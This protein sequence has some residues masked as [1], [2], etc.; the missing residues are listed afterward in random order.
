MDYFLIIAQKCL[1]LSVN[2]VGATLFDLSYF[3]FTLGWNCAQK[4][5]V[6]AVSDLNASKY[7]FKCFYK[8]LLSELSRAK[9]IRSP[10]ICDENQRSRVQ[11]TVLS[12]VLHPVSSCPFSNS[13]KVVRGTLRLD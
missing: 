10:N 11:G 9:G 6:E 8:K 13:G 5:Y 4:P 12:W 3:F 1:E 2:G 7:L